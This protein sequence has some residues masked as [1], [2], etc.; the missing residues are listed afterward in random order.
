[1]TTSTV[2]ILLR[3]TFALL[4]CERMRK[5]A[6]MKVVVIVVKSFLLLDLCAEALLNFDSALSR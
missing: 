5:S 6:V 3:K 2:N 4:L 1:M